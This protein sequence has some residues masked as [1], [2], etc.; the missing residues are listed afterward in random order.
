MGKERK[1]KMKGQQANQNGY[2]ILPR[3]KGKPPHS[4]P[5]RLTS[6]QRTG[7][8]FNDG[9]LTGMPSLNQATYLP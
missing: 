3:H 8:I 4:I 5:I 6:K 1:G 7:N 2:V 9:L